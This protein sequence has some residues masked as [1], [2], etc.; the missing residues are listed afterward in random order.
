MEVK[1][2]AVTGSPRKGGNTEV[3]VAA[4][5]RGVV[6]AGGEVETVRL[7][8][9]AIGPCIGCGGCTKTGQ[10]VVKDD[11]QPLYSKIDGA[12]AVIIASPVYFY[13]LS[14]QTKAFVDRLQALWSR[15]QLLM[16]EGKWVPDISR[17]GYLVSVAAT[18]GGKLFV[19]SQ[20]C[21]EYAFDAIGISYG[22][23]FF[24]RGVDQRGALKTMTAKIE[25]AELFGE[26]LCRGTISLNFCK[27]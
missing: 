4:I 2:L 22:G 9:Y 14:A 13:A 17:K 26:A 18:K 24:V 23:N 19:G 25:E 3:L 20:L 16:K 15:K 27:N 1:V 6:R 21:A 7:P 5:A 10:C 8:D 11:M 12:Q